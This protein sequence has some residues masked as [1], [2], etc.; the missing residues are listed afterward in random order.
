MNNYDPNYVPHKSFAL[1]GQKAIIV[2]S[3]NK[4]LVLRRSDKV[5]DTGKWSLAGG[6]IGHG[7]E[8][9]A[10]ILREVSEETDVHVSEPRPFY[11]HSFV[12]KENDFVVIIGYWC[13]ANTD[14]VRLNWEHSEYKWL[15]KTD[16]LGLDLT[17]NGRTFIEN[18]LL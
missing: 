6:A 7:E 8:P 14:Q 9:V 2:N 18:F 1:V 15:T 13:R 11:T 16:A 4:I 12:N 3:E 10:S 17:P 5:D